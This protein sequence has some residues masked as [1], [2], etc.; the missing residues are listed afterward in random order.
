MRIIIE[1]ESTGQPEI[2]TSPASYDEQQRMYSSHASSALD[3]GFAKIPEP[4][5]LVTGCDESNRAGMD[6]ASQQS[7]TTTGID[8]GSFNGSIQPDENGN[9]L[10]SAHKNDLATAV[11]SG[12]ALDAG[13]PQIEGV[14][15]GGTMASP[16]NSMGVFD[17]S[18]ALS[19]GEFVN[20]EII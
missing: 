14:G 15:S 3:A 11:S 5:M 13:S 18:N 19:G 9:M 4:D 17:R 6:M 20:T 12:S 1:V 7:N 10:L 2:K 16:E 8:G